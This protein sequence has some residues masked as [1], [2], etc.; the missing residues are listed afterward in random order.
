M[1]NGGSAMIANNSSRPLSI[2]RKIKDNPMTPQVALEL[3]SFDE[4]AQELARRFPHYALIVNEQVMIEASKYLER[5][6]F[7]GEYN[8]LLGLIDTL[9]DTVS[10]QKKRDTSTPQQKFMDSIGL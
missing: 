9:H 2:T 4:L 8:V 10:A 3:A 5:Q 1:R 7:K 6:A